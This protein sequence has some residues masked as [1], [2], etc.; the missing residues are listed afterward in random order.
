LPYIEGSLEPEMAFA[1]ADK[2]GIAVSYSSSDALRA[3]NDFPLQS[4]LNI[5][6]ASASVLSDAN[7]V[8]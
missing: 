3:G 1:L 5:Y 6:N 4:F 8:V 2:N 7:A